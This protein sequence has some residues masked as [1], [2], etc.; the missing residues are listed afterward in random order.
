MPALPGLPI[1]AWAQDPATDPTLAG[2]AGPVPRPAMTVRPPSTWRPSRCCATGA[3]SCSAL[4]RGPL[5]G[6]VHYEFLPGLDGG[7]QLAYEQGRKTSES[8]L[9]SDRN[10]P[11]IGTGG[12]YGAISNGRQ[13]RSRADNTNRP[14]PGS[15]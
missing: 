10:L 15:T 9:L 5:E 13:A 3:R 2:R 8:I 4:H 7:L 14:H 1:A 6:G 11:N 12:S